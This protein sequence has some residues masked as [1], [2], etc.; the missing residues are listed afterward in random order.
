M[1]P[2]G[3][4]VN[5][6]GPPA[7]EPIAIV[8]M[9][10]VFPGAANLAGFWRNIVHG[11]DATGDVPPSRWDPAQYPQLRSRRGGFIEGLTEFD[12]LLYG[13][14]PAAV[15]NGE[16]E[17]FLS[18]AVVHGALR[19]MARGREFRRT[20]QV[21]A[22]IAL[23][24]DLPQRTD[25]VVGR[26]GGYGSNI[27]EYT[28]LQIEFINQVAALL[29]R[30]LPPASDGDGLDEIRRLLATGLA[31]PGDQELMLASA[32]PNMVSGRVSNR[33]DFLGGN[34]TV[35]AA[36]A[37]GLIATDLVLRSLRDRR[38][39][40]GIAASVH[41]VQKPYFWYAFELLRAPSRTGRCRPFAAD[42]D[43]LLIGE[44]LGAVVLKRL[45]D[46]ERDGDRVYAVLRG[47]GTSSD[48]RGKGLLTPRTEGQ[49]V[50][51]RRAYEESGLD[52]GSV[53]LI[54]AHGT[55]MPVGDHSEIAA[56]HQVFGR[57]GFP[58]VALGSV[59]SMIGHTMI[60]AGMAG[61][62]KAA[63][64][65]YH[66]TLP[67]TLHVEQVH[68]DL[69]E[70]RLYVNTR[71][72]PWVAPLD[73]PRRAGVNAFG[74]GGINTHALLEDAAD[75][76]PRESLTP[77]GS[78]LIVL[79]A[80]TVADLRERID[81]WAAVLPALG[82]EDLASLAWTASRQF[83]PDEP[84]RLAVTAT[85]IADLTA[86]WARARERLRT[87]S[88]ERWEDDGLSFAAAPYPGQVAFLFRGLAFPG[89]AGGYTERLAD[90]CLHFPEVRWYLDVAEGLSQ[91]TETLPYPL[92]YQ[93]FPP[94]LTDARTRARL[95]RELI[96]S[97]RT[98]VAQ[99]MS[100]LA[101]WNL[102]QG[103][104]LRPDALSGF[105]LGEW[106]ALVAAGVLDTQVIAEILEVW[107]ALGEVPDKIAGIWGMVGAAPDR[108][109]P[110]L[111][112]GPETRPQQDEPVK[113]IMD[114]TGAQTFIA[115]T[116]DGVQAVLQA[117]RARGWL[118]QE[119]P[120][121]AIH[122]PLAAPLLEG[123]R[124]VLPAFEFRPPRA[125]V[126][127]SMNG[128]PYPDDPTQILDWVIGSHALPVRG[129]DTIR[130]MYEDGVR[131]FVEVGVGGK[132]PLQVA[133]AVGDAPFVTVSMDTRGS[134]GL[135]PLHRMLGRL[136]VLGVP[137]DL[138]RLYRNRRC[139]EIDLD[140]PRPTPTKTARPMSLA[141]P[142]TQLPDESV[143][144]LREMLT[145]AV[146][147]PQAVPQPAPANGSGQR[148]VLVEAMATMDHFLK[149]QQQ[150]EESEAKL[151]TQY[152]EI[153]Q[154]ALTRFLTQSRH[155]GL[156]PA[157]PGAM[158]SRPHPPAEKHDFNGGPRKHATPPGTMLLGEV[159]RLEPG[160]ELEAELVLDLDRHLFLAD[161]AFIKI[162]E[163][164]R[165]VEERLPILPMTFGFELL[166]EAAQL[167]APGE[168]VVACR[169]VTAS[170]WIALESTRTLPLTIRA[171]RRNAE[172]E[173]ELRSG[174][175]D[176]PALRGRVVLGPA[177]PP[178][179]A[180]REVAAGQPCPNQASELY[181]LPL[182][183]H[184]PR[185]HVV[186]TLH[187]Q[188]DTTLIADLTVRD[189]AEWVAGGAPAA[190]LFDPVL[191]DGLGQA[192]GYKLLLEGSNIYP[193]QLGRLTRYRQ[194]PPPGS[195]VRAR[196]QCRKLD[197]RLIQFDADVLD[198]AGRV[199]FRV[200]D[201]K[202]WRMMWPREL[203]AFCRRP[204][205]HRIG[206]PWPTRAPASA[207]CMPAR[208]FG[209]MPPDWVARY[210]LTAREWETYR[211][212]PRLDWLLGR[213]ALKDAVRDW[214]MQH[215]G[216]HLLHL[217]IEIANLASGAP[218]VVAPAD[219]P[220]AVSVTHLEDEARA[221]VAQARGVGVDLAL[222]RDRGTE[223]RDQAFDR[224]EQQVLAAT[225]G[226]SLAWLHRAWCAKEALAKAH[227]LGL[228][229][230]PRFRV[231]AIEPDGV[232][233]VEFR[234][235]GK[236]HAVATFLEN[237]RASAS[238][239]LE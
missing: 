121:P 29:Q 176:K 212:Q 58:E 93:L 81:R 120:F 87:S 65:I 11:V 223:F 182:M 170:R 171:R 211:K 180:P 90:L 53:T 237:D 20:G 110:L 74:F 112:P 194:A 157:A 144:R 154:A 24:N 156:G 95:E 143:N 39:D 16:A 28:Y 4:A 61:L 181:T 166:A 56:L 114:G 99:V 139:R 173:V 122:T 17:Q 239:T 63:L 199:W 30:M 9:E 148:P 167:L 202:F 162:P 134:N 145:P 52:P 116:V 198:P 135:E 221:V 227:Q 151:L 178:P 150:H 229:A 228:A 82:D 85:G 234:P 238:V 43:G 136:A 165:P 38:C 67:P 98:P 84:V 185:F 218:V 1:N 12:P 159:G 174:N 55:G 89:L 204:Q 146:A 175:N 14:M 60:S 132:W 111:G 66:R 103:L 18:F 80:S 183:F 42:A 138:G 45:A 15:Q 88:D 232:M 108:V 225:G 205:D 119:I 72:R 41:L 57:T 189:P 184:G 130:Q 210:C 83:N 196:I 208:L 209:D 140:H 5:G 155:V 26:G 100:T 76:G 214:Y 13:L 230:L 35:D 33:F 164:Y 97:R 201:W 186:T 216:R 21:P 2:V 226:D 46:A 71:P 73:R 124:A 27:L 37:S 25:V 68:A 222:V 215:Q 101:I 44:G 6:G 126:Y 40:L 51:L 160:R 91:L 78:E 96:W 197:S 77:R 192:M 19:D 59:K 179:P 129:R 127:C 49:V 220:L 102:L 172:I 195:V 128:R 3:V 36:C 217:D 123:F 233:Q 203:A 47:L 141:P 193:L 191:L 235:E 187:G 213:L 117:A 153:Q 177:L 104:G 152:L 200:E 79:T 32:I 224:D 118:A 115:G 219:V 190:P 34:Y 75:A 105:S 147:A 22:E 62:I 106:T 107:K 70:S 50:A 206:L 31:D 133:D 10:C 8:G 168:C 64:A 142:R 125:R 86:R 48:G 158:L 94:P 92:S 188:T 113:V 137:F 163:K 7:P 169:D 236:L 207:C 23:P 161:H 109:E 231:R 69:G 149:V 54:E 131:I